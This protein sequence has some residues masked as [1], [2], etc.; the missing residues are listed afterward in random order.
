MF[1]E[2]TLFD[3]FLLKKVYDVKYQEYELLYILVILL[4]EGNKMIESK[5]VFEIQM[6]NI[7]LNKS[8]NIVKFI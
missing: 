6:K 2:K 3:N 5:I 8:G 4:K 7:I 1:K